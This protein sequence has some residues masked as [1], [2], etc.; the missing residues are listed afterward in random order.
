MRGAMSGSVVLAYLYR[1]L[2]KVSTMHTSQ[3]HGPPTL[4]HVKRYLFIYVYVI[5]IMYIKLI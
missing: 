1:E 4:L 2:Y 5:L 3:F